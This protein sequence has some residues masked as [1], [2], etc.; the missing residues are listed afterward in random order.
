MHLEKRRLDAANRRHDYLDGSFAEIVLIGGRVIV[1]ATLLP[2]HRWSQHVKPL[3]STDSCQEEHVGY[4]LSGAFRVMMDD[5]RTEAFG[6]G[7]LYAIPPGH[8]A[9]IVG[10]STCICLDVGAS[11]R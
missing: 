4:V 3:A 5:G 7:D 1:R 8:D 9:E 6:P 11:H 10:E 2:G